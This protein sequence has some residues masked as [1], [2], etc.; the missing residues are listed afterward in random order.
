MG[1]H[2]T[3]SG[4]DIISVRNTH[5]FDDVVANMM[6]ASIYNAS[7]PTSKAVPDKRKAYTCGAPSGQGAYLSDAEIIRLARRE[8]F[9]IAQLGHDVQSEN[10]PT[11]QA[12]S[13]DEIN[14]FDGNMLALLGDLKNIGKSSVSVLT[15]L[16]KSSSSPRKLASAWLSARYGD[17]LTYKDL[18]SLFAGFTR[19]AWRHSRHTSYLRGRSR[20]TVTVEYKDASA[21][22]HLSTQIAVTP[23]DYN[24]LMKSVRRAYEWDYYPSLGNIWDLIPLSFVVDWFVDVSSIFK[25]LDRLVQARYYN[26]TCVLETVKVMTTCNSLSGVDLS[27]YDRST[28]KRLSLGMSSVQLGLPSAINIVDGVSLLLM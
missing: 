16:M 2:G 1:G 13:F 14:R 27:Y 7:H 18:S 25:D 11:L 22:V 17:R 15:D 5:T 24:G 23:K 12:E 4:C 21:V 10:R 6:A 20:K 19:S 26:V 3:A 9:S 8:L 28:G